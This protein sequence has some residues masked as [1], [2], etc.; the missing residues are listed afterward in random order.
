MDK[1]LSFEE[2]LILQD[3]PIQYRPPSYSPYRTELFTSKSDYKRF[4]T[5]KLI[6]GAFLLFPIRLVMFFIAIAGASISAYFANKSKPK[7]S[8]GNPPDMKE[9]AWAEVMTNRF[10]RLM[11]FS[12]GLTS[13]EFKGKVPVDFDQQTPWL[14]YSVI[15]APHS[16]HFDWALIVSRATR[17]LSPV[18]KAQAGDAPYIQK[19]I[20][21]TMPI[22][23]RR[24][25]PESRKEAAIDQHRRITE[26]VEKGWFPVLCFPEGTN[27]NR[28][29]LARFKVG[30]FLAGKPLIP[31][32]IKYL[33]DDKKREND[34]DLV[35]MAHFGRSVL[36][37]VL[38]CMCRMQTKLEYTFM[39]PYFPTEEEKNNPSLY[40]ENVRQLMAKECKLEPSDWTFEDVKLM[41]YCAKY[42][43]TPE[44]GAI[45][46]SKIF[47]GFAPKMQE[48]HAQNLLEEYL[49]ILRKY[50]PKR[51]ENRVKGLMPVISKAIIL[52]ELLT[53]DRTA[54]AAEV[55]EGDKNNLESEKNLLKKSLLDDPMN[56]EYLNENLPNYVSFEQLAT[57]YAKILTRIKEEKSE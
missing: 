43:F 5:F 37:S 10:I 22:L 12:M 55:G 53:E 38:V 47:G 25:S 31:V 3:E 56:E 32:C 27:G 48:S 52:R 20:R 35:T 41:R 42:K 28:K 49:S 2:D 29:Q 7:H 54:V 13:I 6:L 11:L 44:I 24:E 19:V 18:I 51:A 33:T 4:Q 46:V 39:D 57:L 23:V 30:P 40:A 36:T 14:K 15:A 50:M 8:F 21:V 9:A 34:N 45:K 26:G 17:L 1:E 16:A